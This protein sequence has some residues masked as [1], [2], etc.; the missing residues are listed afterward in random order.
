M[1]HV[2]LS[3]IKYTA[4]SGLYK[5][6]EQWLEKY[7]VLKNVKQYIASKRQISS[8]YTSY[9]FFHSDYPNTLHTSTHV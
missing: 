1:F 4:T 6:V 7:I 9:E 5:I 2:H 3:Y 8:H